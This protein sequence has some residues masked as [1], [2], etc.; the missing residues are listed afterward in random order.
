MF[1]LYPV[2]TM[3]ML[4]SKLMSSSFSA[5]DDNPADRAALAQLDWTAPFNFIASAAD[6]SMCSANGVVC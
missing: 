6:V 4:Q 5:S 1:E 2:L 3:H